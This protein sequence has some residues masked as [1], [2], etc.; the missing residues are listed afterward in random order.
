MTSM[1][2]LLLVI[3]VA[4]LFFAQRVLKA[5]LD[6]QQRQIDALLAEVEGL[7][8]PRMPGCIPSAR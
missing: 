4:A 7:K 1:L 3:C 6:K 2:V 8:A 5:R